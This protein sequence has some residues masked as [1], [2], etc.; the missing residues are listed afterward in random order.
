MWQNCAQQAQIVAYES[1]VQSAFQDVANALAAREQLDKAYDALSKQ[2]RASK[3]ALRLVGLRYKHGVSGA[4]DLLDAERQQLF[5]GRCG[6]V[7]TTDRAENLADLYKA[8]GGGLNGIPKPANNRPGKQMPSE[9]I[10]FQTAFL[11]L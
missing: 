2:S 10:R 3:E 8:L 4:L 11:S 6:F 9:T 5:G 7:G 1:A